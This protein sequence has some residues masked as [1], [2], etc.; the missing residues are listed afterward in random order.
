MAGEIPVFISPIDVEI[1]G[2]TGRY[3]HADTVEDLAAMLLSSKLTLSKAPSFHR[4]L[5]TSLEAL[6]FYTDA[7]SARA[8]FVA[9]AHEAGLHVV[10]D[11]VAAEKQAEKKEPHIEAGLRE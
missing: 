7:A 5:M 10:P 2:N 1:E 8:A 11:D 4:A 6:E 3:R 9:V